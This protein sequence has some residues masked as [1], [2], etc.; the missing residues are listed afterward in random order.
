M[1]N[2]LAYMGILLEIFAVFL[3]LPTIVAL[4]YN[5]SLTMFLIPM[6]ISLFCGV[7]L[8]KN[9]RRAQLDLN[10]GL[11]LTAITFI[12]FSFIGSIPYYSI[13]AGSQTPILNSFFEAMSGFTTTGLTVI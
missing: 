1:K 6:I 9:F 2:I 7:I 4:I 12:F 5:E 11:T 8:D 13:F 10:E 3:I